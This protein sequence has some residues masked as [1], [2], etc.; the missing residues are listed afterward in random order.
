MTVF[1]SNG[2]YKRIIN[3]F[4]D[5]DIFERLREDI[6]INKT[7]AL[8]VGVFWDGILKMKLMTAKPEQIKSLGHK[9]F[10]FDSK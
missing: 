5:A 4:E 8:I 7:L 9:K 6:E 3:L 10:H 2:Y 1:L